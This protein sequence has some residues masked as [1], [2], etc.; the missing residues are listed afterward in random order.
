MSRTKKGSATA[1]AP[2]DAEFWTLYGLSESSD[3]RDKFVA[4]A[5]SEISRRGI[6]DV[7]ARSLCDLL[8]V[9]YSL[10][11]YHFGSFDGLL[12]EVFV[13]AHDLW[14]GCIQQALSAEYSNPEERFRGVIKAQIQRAETYGSVIGLAHLPHVSENVERILNEK[15]PERLALTVAYSIAISAILIKDLRTE[16]MSSCDIEITDLPEALLI[17]ELKEVMP[18][19]ARLQWALVGPTLWM[20]G[21]AG[22]HNDIDERDEQI[23][24]VALLDAYIDRLIISAKQD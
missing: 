2:L 23:Q 17:G 3:N 13:K 4:L 6:L 14:V 18:S 1:P 5:M 8:G 7:N 19:A 10:V 11:T 24:I 9:D 22:G 12:A 21:S 16:T 20:T 15:F